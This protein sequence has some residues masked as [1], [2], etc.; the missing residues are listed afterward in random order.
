MPQR[1]EKARSCQHQTDWKGKLNE[2]SREKC[3]SRFEH[4]AKHVLSVFAVLIY[5]KLW[6][7][8]SARLQFPYIF[9]GLMLENDA[10]D[11]LFHFTLELLHVECNFLWHFNLFPC[12]M[13]F[14]FSL[15]HCNHHLFSIC[16]TNFEVF[17]NCGIFKTSGDKT[18]MFMCYRKD[19]IVFTNTS[20]KENPILKSGSKKC[21][22]ICWI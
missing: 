21:F 10:F 12:S 11:H 13:F 6:Y 8:S 1:V 2:T 5:V 4:Q 19:V 18:S 16:K 22:F 9:K 14:S 15:L 17:P 7:A 20:D 3:F